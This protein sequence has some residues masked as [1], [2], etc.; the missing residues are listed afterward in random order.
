MPR[1]SRTPDVIAA[2]PPS[3]GKRLQVYYR[4]WGFQKA[5]Y[6]AMHKDKPLFFRRLQ[7]YRDFA[8]ANGYS[9]IWSRPL[10]SDDRLLQLVNQLESEQK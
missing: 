2:M 3:S 10:T 9:G 8:K 4:L 1:M 5:P 7:E 6:F